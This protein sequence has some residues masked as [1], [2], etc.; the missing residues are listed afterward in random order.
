MEILQAKTMGFC[1]GVR[2][3]VKILEA[4]LEKG[5][6][7]CTYGPLIHNTRY[8][9]E[10]EKKGVR[11]ILS[12][13]E[14]KDDE[15]LILPSHG[16]E[17]G[18]LEEIRKLGIKYIDATCPIVLESQKI[19]ADLNA[20]GIFTVIVGDLDHTEIKSIKSHAKEGGFLVTKDPEDLKNMKHE[21]LAV[22]AQT[23]LREDFFKNFCDILKSIIPRLEVLNTICGATRRRQEAVMELASRSDIIIVV[24]G[25]NS[26]NTKKLY[27]LSS[28]I[29]KKSYHV[30]SVGELDKS[31]FNGT[32]KIGICSGASTPDEQVRE[33]IEWLKR[34]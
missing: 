28:E 20:R 29:Q 16:I 2:R 10:L 11:Q 17:K 23:T 13:K 12:F 34:I 21:E 27:S 26:S 14:L 15:I 18:K 24:G 4:E 25:K 22:L 6:K 19:V 7:L 3:A 9:G 31:L 30:E 5:N 33:I 8:I 1:S 32:D